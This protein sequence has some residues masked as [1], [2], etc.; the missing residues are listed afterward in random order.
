MNSF[1]PRTDHVGP[2]FLL[3]LRHCFNAWARNIKSL[4][5][6]SLRSSFTAISARLRLDW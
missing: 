3:P 4:T 1:P 5:A 6:P 2:L